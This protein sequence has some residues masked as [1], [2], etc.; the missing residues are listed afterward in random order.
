MQLEGAASC[1]M[2]LFLFCLISDNFVSKEERMQLQVHLLTEL[3]KSIVLG[4]N[5]FQG[6]ARPQTNEDKS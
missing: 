1:F 3:C 2:P 4:C 6:N 5:K